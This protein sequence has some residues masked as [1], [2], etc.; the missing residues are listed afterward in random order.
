MENIPSDDQCTQSCKPEVR[1]WQTGGI[2]AFLDRKS[3][4]FF[5]S[6]LPAAGGKA[7]PCCCSEVRSEFFG[8]KKHFRGNMCRG[9]IEIW[10]NRNTCCRGLMSFKFWERGVLGGAAITKYH[11]LK[12]VQKAEMYCLPVLEVD[13]W[14][15]SISR[16]GF[17]WTLRE[18]SVHRRPL[19][20]GV[21]PASVAFLGFRNISLILHLFPVAF[22]FCVWLC[23][24]FSSL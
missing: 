13:V 10:E 20:S 15:Q 9:W 18:G 11:K 4:G 7:V 24:N 12:K 8:L 22:F 3:L 14:N 23:P 19:A 16:V 6:G 5:A 1:W 17:F 21:L 2:K